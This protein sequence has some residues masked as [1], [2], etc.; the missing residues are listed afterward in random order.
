M[1]VF[2]YFGCSSATKEKKNIKIKLGVKYGV[3]YGVKCGSIKWR[4]MLVHEL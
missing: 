4:T 1:E 3:K 2:H